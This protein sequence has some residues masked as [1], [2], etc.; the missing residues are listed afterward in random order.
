[1]TNVHAM[2]PRPPTTTLAL[3]AHELQ[4]L[5]AAID[6]ALHTLSVQAPSEQNAK[7]GVR[8]LRARLGMALCALEGP[9]GA[10]A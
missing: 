9:K 2:R 10:P 4:L 6:T 7:L 3:N 8:M 1:M 5:V